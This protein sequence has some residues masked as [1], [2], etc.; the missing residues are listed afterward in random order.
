MI[1]VLGFVRGSKPDEMSASQYYRVYLPLRVVNRVSNGIGAET[2]NIAQC[3]AIAKSEQT[4]GVDNIELE[5]RDVYTMNGIYGGF[6]QAFLDA[7][8]EQDGLFV[9]DSDDDLTEDFKLVS[10]RGEEFKRVLAEV[11]YVTTSTQALAKHYSQYT[12]A[13]P[14]VLRN[15]LDVDWMV[16]ISSRAKRLVTGL[17]IGFTGSRTHWQDWR[18]PSVPFARILREYSGQVTGIV[19]GEAP[20]YMYYA[21]KNLA[22]FDIVPFAIYPVVLSQFDIVLCAVD[23]DDKFNDGK[24]AV[25]ALEAMCVGAVPICSR[26]GPYMDMWESGAPIVIVMEDS[27]DGW[28]EAIRSVLEDT[29]HRMSLSRRGVDWVKKYRSMSNTGH[30]DW[31]LFYWSITGD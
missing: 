30:V 9:L 11:D 3:E 10:S 18:K 15:H 17:T 23:A 5:G 6:H 21:A 22:T 4:D 13:R 24:S 27:P 28:Y 25:K 2:V 31:S 12:K 1:D 7:I 29:D 8:H 16:Y 20:Q 26:F 19:H 14:T